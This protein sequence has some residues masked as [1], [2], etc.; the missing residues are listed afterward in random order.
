MTHLTKVLQ[1]SNALNLEISSTDLELLDKELTKIESFDFSQNFSL[2]RGDNLCSLLSL[3]SSLGFDFCYIDPPYNTGKKFIYNDSFPKKNHIFGKNSQWMA[4]MLPRLVAIHQSLKDDAAIAVS[5]DDN[6][7]PYLRVLLDNIFGEENFI[8]NICVIRSKNGKGS[9]KNVATNHEYLVIYSKSSKFS[10]GGFAPD[11]DLYNLKDEHGQFRINGLFRKKGDASLREDRP[12]MYFPLYY[13]EE[14]HVFTEKQSNLKE[15]FPNDSKGI[16]RRWLWGKDTTSLQSWMLYAS[17][18]G[19]IY[20]KDYFNEEKL[21]KPRTVWDESDFYT[22]RAT[23][24]IKKI[25]GSKVFDTPKPLAY[26]E[27]ILEVFTK[28]NALIL[29]AFAGTGTTAHA[30]FSLNEKGNSNRKVLLMESNNKIPEKSIAYKHNFNE[31][32][33]ITEER[34][35]YLKKDNPNFTYYTFDVEK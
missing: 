12:N 32:A 28:K 31:I 15:T 26:I 4:Y 8:A 6:A 27:N 5:I 19:I 21:I 25:Y 7:Q 30:S 33:D 17:K 20:V 13:D 14:G 22:E 2:I 16:E 24:E 23:N 34:L 1:I 29:D 10:A 35:R 18:N 3:P 11:L 9:N